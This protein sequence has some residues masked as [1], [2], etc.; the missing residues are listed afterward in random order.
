MSDGDLI[1]QTMIGCQHGT[2]RRDQ[3]EK[4]CEHDTWGKL[5]NLRME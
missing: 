3:A 2:L 1:N 5:E 4:G